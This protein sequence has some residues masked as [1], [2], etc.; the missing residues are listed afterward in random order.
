MPTY[1]LATSMLPVATSRSGYVPREVIL[2]Q[3]FAIVVDAMSCGRTVSPIVG[4]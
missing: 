1:G 3:H 2:R 4:R